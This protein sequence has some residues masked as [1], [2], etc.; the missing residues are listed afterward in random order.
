MTV[1]I[2][3][4]NSASTPADNGDQVSANPVAITP[5]ASMQAGDLV[6]VFCQRRAVGTVFALDASG[7][8]TWHT[9]ALFTTSGIAVQVFW[10]RFNGTWAADPSIDCGETLPATLVMHVFRPTSA[11]SYWALEAAPVATEV[12]APDSP[13]DVSMPG[14]TTRSSSSVTVYGWFTA[15]D[16]TWASNIF[17]SESEELAGTTGD[18]QYRNTN[19]SDQSASFSHR[20][21]T[22]PGATPQLTKRQSALGGD[23]VLTLLA[24]WREY[25]AAQVARSCGMGLGTDLGLGL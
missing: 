9:T 23:A 16:N 12:A 11:L 15:D 20:I 24:T 7:G 17:D 4:H 1:A 2:T 18:A 14:R 21:R 10:C 19:G 3:Y 8:Q 6:I 13:F 22:A 5:P 25:T